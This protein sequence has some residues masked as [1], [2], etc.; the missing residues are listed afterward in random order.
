M[1]EK[2]RIPELVELDD[3][4]RRLALRIWEAFDFKTPLKECEDAVQ[5][6]K[7]CRH[8]GIDPLS[9]LGPGMETFIRLEQAEAQADP[10]GTGEPSNPRH[11]VRR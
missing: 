9:I 2:T 6:V 4:D 11:P 10:I 3:A 7:E 1:A 8:H 5:V